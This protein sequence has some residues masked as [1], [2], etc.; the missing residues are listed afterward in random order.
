MFDYYFTFRSVTPAQRAQHVLQKMNISAQ[1][2]RLP[3]F[4]SN[5]GC[6]YAVVVG[7]AQGIA[8]ANVL[9]ANGVGYG[10]VYKIFF[11]G[12]FEETAL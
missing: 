10:A 4:L 7:A 2:R 6:G 8:A 9:R 11:D 3:K 12:G 5:R 1:V